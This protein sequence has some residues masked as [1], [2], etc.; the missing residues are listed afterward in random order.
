MINSSSQKIME[1]NQRVVESLLKIVM[2][3]GK[4]GLALR[5]HRDDKIVWRDI[6]DEHPNEGNFVELVRFQAE[7]DPI[8]AQYLTNSP[9]NA[10]YTSKMIQNKLVEVIGNSICDDIVE[11]KQA[12]FYSVIVDELK[13]QT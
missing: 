6:G 9:R 2:L 7:T 5:G 1:S 11:V 3:C 10:R 12:K 4:Q 8:L 13:L